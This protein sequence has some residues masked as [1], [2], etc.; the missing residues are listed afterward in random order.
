MST[1][2]LELPFKVTK[3]KQT[4][5][6]DV[7]IPSSASTSK[8]PLPV[9]VWWHGGGLLQGTRKGTAPHLQN[10]PEK[11][12]IIVVSADYRL[13]PQVRMPEIL[14]DAGDVLEWIQSKEFSEKTNNKAD[15]NKVFVSGSS[16]GGWLAFLTASGL[17]YKE[18]GLKPPPKPFGC[19]AI[20]PI[21]DLKDSFW[22]TKQHPVT[23][24][25]RVIDGEK[26]LG[27]NLDPKSNI[28]TSSALDAP[29]SVFYHYMIQE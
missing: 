17:G 24:F 1:Q 16:A 14:S 2:I 18:C 26:E 5:F 25:P 28:L 12:N 7:H 11:H 23:Y 3:D 10:A 15:Q 20:Y 13:A 29:R 9:L 21:S 19:I 22:N 4:I 27:E 6:A 8:Q